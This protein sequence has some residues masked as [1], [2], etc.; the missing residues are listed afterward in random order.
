MSRQTTRSLAAEAIGSFFLFAGVIGSGIMAATLSGGNN[1]VALLANTIATGAILFVMIVL[2]G[3]ISG[4]H[5]N[6]AV[7]L[8]LAVRR[9]I[10]PGGAFA[11]V[12]AQ[13][14]G[15][16]LA[17]LAVHFMFDLPLFQLSAHPR[18]GPGQWLAEGIATFGLLFTV[19]GVAGR[20]PA[21]AAAAVALYIVA[22]YWF[23]AS[24]S[25]ANPAITIARSLSDSFAGIAPADVPG[26]IIA[27][28]I[29]AGLG[30]WLGGLLFAKDSDPA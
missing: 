4:A 11:Y 16:L 26:F 27:Q 10:A 24:T 28:L 6:P 13:L 1:G 7:T 21:E 29:G 19:M 14:V 23:T 17:V 12:V 3:P 9:Q 25:F 15:G 20:K 22:A 5:F 8:A 2:L 30:A 18:T